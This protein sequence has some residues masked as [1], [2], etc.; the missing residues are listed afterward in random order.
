MIGRKHDEHGNRCSCRVLADLV[1]C[2]PGTIRFSYCLDVLG[3]HWLMEC[4][5]ACHDEFVEPVRSEKW[6]D[7]GPIDPIKAILIRNE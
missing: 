2:N 5:H 7:I 6:R 3:K 4:N 1:G